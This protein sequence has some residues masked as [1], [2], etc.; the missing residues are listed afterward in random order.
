MSQIKQWL[1][2]I[3]I[4]VLPL[5][6]VHTATAQDRETQVAEALR[7]N[8]LSVTLL[9][10]GRYDEAIPLAASA[11]RILEPILGPDHPQLAILLTNL[12]NLYS[13]KHDYARAEPLYRRAVKIL[14]QGSDP[15]DPKLAEALNSLGT[16]LR[17]KGEYTESE[18]LHNRAWL[19]FEETS[20]QPSLAETLNSLALLYYV[21]GD[22]S[23]AE[24]FGSRALRIREKEYGPNHLKVANSLASLSL[25]YR[26]KDDYKQA[27]RSQKRA[28]EIAEQALNAKDLELATFLNNLASLYDYTGEYEQAE[29]LY[30][31]G[32]KITIDA[33]GPDH[34]DV[35]T[36]LNNFALMYHNRGAYMQAELLQKEALRILEKVRPGHPDVAIVLGGLARLYLRKDN[37]AEAEQSYKR[38]L[39]I[40][41]QSLD[42]GHPDIA[43]ACNNLAEFYRAR[44]DYARA[45]PLYTRALRIF[46]KA[47]GPEHTAV[48]MTLNNLAELS[49]D[50]GDYPE[51]ERLLQRALPIL[52]K[53]LGQ[54]HP[55]VEAALFNLAGVYRSKG[56]NDNALRFLTRAMDVQEHK[57]SLLL[58]IGSQNQKQLYLNTTSGPNFAISLHVRSAPQ[59]GQAARLALTSILQHKGRVLDAMTDQIGSLRRH[60]T[61]EVQKLLGTLAETRSHLAAL[62]I[63]GGGKLSPEERRAEVAKL[64]REAERLE[65]EASRV[66]VEFRA[67]QLPTT[68][69]AIRLAIP[70]DAALVEISS[71][72]NRVDEKFE[73]RRYV[74]YVARRNEAVPQWVD[75][76]ESELIDKAAARWRQALSNPPLK[77]R[78]QISDAEF[79]QRA[80]QHEAEV[81][82]LAR[83]LDKRLMQPIRT[84]LG[85]TR[86][87]FLSPDADLNLIP[88]AALVDENGSYLVENYSI[89]YLT[90]GRDLL[91]L[92]PSTENPGASVV[93]AD[94][95]YD[96]SPMSGSRLP[97]DQND[98]PANQLDQDERLIDF[99]SKTYAPLP[100]TEQEATALVR[101]LPPAQ[102][103]L[104]EQATEAA[105]KQVKSPR[106]LHIATH[107]FFFPDPD[108][109][110]PQD[111]KSERG[112]S[113]TLD[114]LSVV[115]RQDSPLFRS[116]LVLAGVKQAKS[117]PKEDGVVTALEVAGLDLWNTKL[118][119]L[120]ACETGLG[121]VTNG[122]GVYGLR[123]SLVLAGSESQ[124]MSLWKVSDSGTRHLMTAYYTRL[125]KGEG[126]SEALR[127]VQ[128]AM[129]QGKLTSATAPQSG[130]RGTTDTEAS[131]QPKNYRRPYYWAAFIQS[132]DWRSMGPPIISKRNLTTIGECSIL[133]SWCGAENSAP[134][135]IC[136]GPEADSHQLT[137]TRRLTS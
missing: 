108:P 86:R 14:E 27:I 134:A 81:K 13:F 21:K 22:Y 6:L 96:L 120:S 133:S 11:L 137:N 106:V 61:P 72:A 32:L 60:A 68:L 36:L 82:E 102:I 65:G 95:L 79:R 125:Q 3:L 105:L 112:P 1:V 130:K 28:K 104:R 107:G 52:E 59:D 31:R 87:V 2:R 40:V 111:N 70:D 131:A 50:T 44:K 94:P 128:L 49:R 46:E 10:Q 17:E 43:R 69:D 7:L 91:R 114:A 119:V 42:A 123:R 93:I 54:Y 66:S 16:S 110:T 29:P 55:Y 4:C 39:Q 117:G 23:R 132:G 15:F 9:N 74:A 92:Q 121:G 116:G 109:A 38:A 51:A 8:K 58:A 47:L 57:V 33:L 56:D 19:I 84:L 99:T 34:P 37:Y 101:L 41:E 63:S 100:C 80:A 113:D 71:Y 135:S 77:K 118:V 85:R 24:S 88:F 83:A 115:N 5:A 53:S 25:I 67:Q 122:A 78:Q 89:S 126:R 30:R 98:Q 75:L 97:C 136:S 20:D 48:A 45:A 129:L 35:A 127:Q 12:A 26:A 124:V 73:P 62:Q 103:L 18:K 76:G 90:S 64:D